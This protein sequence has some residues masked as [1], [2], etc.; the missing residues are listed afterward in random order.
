[1]IDSLNE[2]EAHL[3]DLLSTALSTEQAQIANA[4][5]NEIKSVLSILDTILTN[6]E[7]ENT[8]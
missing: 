8:N 5:L 2:E 1:L 6:L 7:V 4:R 3:T